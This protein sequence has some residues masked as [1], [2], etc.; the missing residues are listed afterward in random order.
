MEEDKIYIFGHRNP[1]TDS[2][3]SAISLSY[4]KNKQGFN[5]EPRI[6][7]NIN[8]ETKYV[9]NKFKFKTPE[10][11][12]DVKLQLKDINYHKGFYVN[13]KD[14]V[15]NAF[16]FMQQNNMSTVPV[17]DKNGKFCGSF[18]MKD[19]AKN[20]ILGDIIHLETN[21][22]HLLTT[23]NGKE[24][25]R[26]N[27]EICG[28][29]TTCDYRSSTF[30]M[31]MLLNNKTILV[32][33]DR[34]SIIEYA[35][36]KRVGTIIITGDNEIKTEHLEIAKKNKINLIQTPKT[37]LEVILKIIFSSYVENFNF[38]EQFVCVEENDY[39]TDLDEVILATKHSYYPVVNNDNKCLGLLKLSDLND[40]K[41]KKV[42][43][44]DHNESSQSI[45]GIEEAEIVG[46]VDHHKL[47]N[48]GTTKPIN[49]RNMP[50][51]STCTIV[52]LLFKE[53]KIKI[54]ENIAGLLIAGI[55]S[56]T[57][58]LKSPT[59]TEIDKDALTNLEKIANIDAE[60]LAMDMFKAND[61]TKNKSIKEIV[62]TD[63]KT[64]N[65]DQKVIGI[66]QI[67]SLNAK[68]ILKNQ[69]QYIKFLNK[70]AKNNNYEIMVLAITDILKNGSYI[71]FNDSAKGI[72][73]LAFIDD[74]EEGYFLDGIVSR[75]KQIVP[76]IFNSYSNFKS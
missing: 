66:G 6:L 32:V 36:N 50:V 55:I 12:N 15:Y 33:G 44:V 18:A 40:R 38:V 22:N 29:V 28:N 2:V 47:G 4:L 16:H 70:E 13:K 49:F 25:L 52:Y 69:E 71:L 53:S 39:I 45:E 34:H 65:Y 31:H 76:A 3:C 26:F 64:F 11:L 74:V 19:I 35:V 51:G 58:L 60:K 43:L 42:I 14:C 5:S 17:V 61:S 56:D 10:I 23:L 63:F 8:D 54:P 62:Y 72:I 75:K 73:K 21:Y 27:D 59:T 30:Q 9:L 20:E 46:V 67:T 68:N 48:L 7:S 1:D 41:L 37:S 57:L 24:L